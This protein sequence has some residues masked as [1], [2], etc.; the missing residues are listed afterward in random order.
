MSLKTNR[1]LP[2]E[3][4][5]QTLDVSLPILENLLTRTNT[6]PKLPLYH[7]Y[8]RLHLPP[9]TIK[10]I[11]SLVYKLSTGYPFRGNYVPSPA[12]GRNYVKMRYPFPIKPTVCKAKPSP[13]S[14]LLLPL[15]RTFPLEVV[16]KHTIRTW[17]SAMTCGKYHLGLC[18]YCICPLPPRP[19][20]PALF[21]RDSRHFLDSP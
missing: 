15:R 10:P 17:P 19:I 5:H 7:R 6:I 18:S 11:A 13:S 14:S 9:L 4:I 12:N 1:K 3:G 2:V 16:Q 20:P 8:H 21:W